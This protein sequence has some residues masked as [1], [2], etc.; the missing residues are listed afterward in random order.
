MLLQEKSFPANHYLWKKNSKSFCCLLLKSGK[1]KMI[2][3]NSRVPKNFYINSGTF[4]GDFDSL[5]EEKK[6]VSSLQT[7]TEITALVF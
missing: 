1:V 3:P 2:A 4:I 7:K 6:T 5:L